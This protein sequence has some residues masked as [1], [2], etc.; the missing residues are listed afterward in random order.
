VQ[1]TLLPRAECLLEIFEGQAYEFG[2]LQY[3]KQQVCVRQ[4]HQFVGAIKVEFDQFFVIN[5]L[6]PFKF[7]QTA[8]AKQRC[9]WI[10][11]LNVDACTMRKGRR[12]IQ[13][14]SP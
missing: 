6:S 5:R 14:R 13:N 1:Q 12:K 11:V 8:E 10:A 4:V 3:R 9:E 2:I 7:I